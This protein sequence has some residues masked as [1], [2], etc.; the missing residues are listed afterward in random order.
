VEKDGKSEADLTGT[1]FWFKQWA[2]VRPE[3]KTKKLDGR[4]WRQLPGVDLLSVPADAYRRRLIDWAQ[5]ATVA[6]IS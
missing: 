3:I 6:D 2:G 4:E 1:P 5:T